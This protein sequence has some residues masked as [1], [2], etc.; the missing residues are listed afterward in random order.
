MNGGDWH[1]HGVLGRGV[2]G[3]VPNPP[4]YLFTEPPLRA[5]GKGVPIITVPGIS[6]WEKT[7]RRC[8]GFTVGAERRKK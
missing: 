4:K 7:P 8:G 3:H 5:K 6:A 2:E 1:G